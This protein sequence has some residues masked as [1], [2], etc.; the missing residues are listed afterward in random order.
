MRVIAT[1]LTR[2]LATTIYGPTG[3]DVLP[4]GLIRGAVTSERS[5]CS[6]SC[7]GFDRTYLSN[8]PIA[9]FMTASSKALDAVEVA[10]ASCRGMAA[11]ALLP[12]GDSS[13]RFVS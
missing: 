13:T 6:R 11:F 2:S 1:D 12:A 8:H 7:P 10:P 4:V 5:R 3:G 9:V